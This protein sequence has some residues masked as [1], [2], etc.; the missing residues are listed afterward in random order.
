MITPQA[1]YKY[2]SRRD[3]V[4]E[5][6]DLCLKELYN[7]SF[8]CFD[9]K[10]ENMSTLDY[11]L[12]KSKQMREEFNIPEGKPIELVGDDGKQYFY[13]GDFF[14]IPLEY[15]NMVIDNYMYAYDIERKWES[16]MDTL[17]DYLNNK[18]NIALTQRYFKNE[19]G[20]DDKQYVN[21]PSIKDAIATILKDNIGENDE[22]LQKI[23]DKIFEHVTCCKKFFKFGLIEENLFRGLVWCSPC[24]DR[25][26]VIRAWKN[27][28]HKDLIVPDDD[29]WT[30]EYD[31]RLDEDYDVDDCCCDYSDCYGDEQKDFDNEC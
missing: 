6:H 14:Y 12:M 4:T 20:Y 27:V 25:N 31:E 15:Q 16:Y 2:K 19:Y 3:I 17:I 11:A 18:D 21:L 29:L 5:A 26:Y 7:A 9:D 23:I 1:V 30:D 10:D 24:T 13:P 8:S 22:L 28:F